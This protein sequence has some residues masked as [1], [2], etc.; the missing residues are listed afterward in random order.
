MRQTDAV[1]HGLILQWGAVLDQKKHSLHGAVRSGHVGRLAGNAQLCTAADSGDRKLF[2]QQANIPVAVAKNSRCDLYT[3]Q[4]NTLFRHG[5]PPELQNL[6]TILYH[7]N[8]Q[9]KTMKSAQNIFLHSIGF[10]I[11]TVS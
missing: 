3:I 10:S 2:F 8:L 7:Q 1:V 9:K 5:A 4:F 6:I 11:R